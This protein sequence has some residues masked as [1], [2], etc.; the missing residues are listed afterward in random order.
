MTGAGINGA[1][2]LRMVY[3]SVLAGIGVTVVFS[4]TI[5]GAIRSTDLRRD[6]RTGAAAA[7]AALATLGLVLTAGIVVFGLVLLTRKG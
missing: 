7:Y 3:A 5:L 6:G 2:L 4:F 1:A